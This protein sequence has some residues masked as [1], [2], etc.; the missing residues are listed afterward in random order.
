M[1]AIRIPRSLRAARVA[2]AA[3]LA[4]A[5]AAGTA[6]A[7]EDEAGE[8]I[9]VTAQNFER[10][11]FAD[12]EAPF[13]ID[14]LASDKFTEP[15]LD[16]PRSVTVI[17]ESV[18]ETLGATSFRELVRTTPGVTLGTGE[19]G[20]AFGDRI[21]IRGFDAR[22]D[23]YVDGVRDPG[24]TGREVF[25]VQQ[26]EIVKGPASTYGG[27]GTTG[28]TVSFVSKQPQEQAFQVYEATLGTDAT[29]RLTADV[30]VPLSSTVA[31][32]LNG[33]LYDADV[34]GRAEVWNQRWGVAAAI[35]WQ[36]SDAVELAADYYHLSTEGLPD[37]GVPFDAA[38]QQPF[39]VP[40][41]NFYGVTARDFASTDVD[42][43]TLRLGWNLAEG[44][45]LSSRLRYG[46]NWN[47]YIA[48]APER[49]VTTNPD[50]SKWT[51]S[52]NPK[53]R[54]AEAQ[55]YANATDLRFDFVTGRFSHALVSGF[56]FSRELVDNYPF[57]FASSETVGS[58]IVPA[59]PITQNL[60]NPDPGQAWPLARTTSGAFSSTKVV[61]KAAYFVDTIDLAP[62]WK[63]SG[64]L[65]YDDY[66]VSLYS[67]TASGASTSLANNSKFLN[68]NAG[69][70][71]KPAPAGSV[72][73]SASTSSNP[74]GEQTDGSG[75][76]Y[77]GLGPQTVNLDPE[78][79]RSFEAGVK[80]EV[81]DGGLLLTG[82]LFRTEKTN[83]RVNDP[84]GGTVQVLDGEQRVQG[85]EL[86]FSGNITSAWAVYG[87]YV[88]LDSEITKSSNPADVGKPF[89]NVA[90]NSA[91]LLS[92]YAF[93]P[94][95]T[96]GGQVAYV[97]QRYGG[98]TAAGTATIP[99]YWRF[100]AMGSYV[101]GPHAELQ[102][103]VLNLTNKVYYDAIYRSAT[104]FAYIAPGISALATLRLNF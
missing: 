100:D 84:L 14:R 15:L 25:A 81:A 16:T 96:A 82:A 6:H 33:V 5:V 30:N 71:W 83:A 40:R 86:G 52:A 28:G 39:D 7:E 3:A 51:V 77:G 63:L 59:I 54:N 73:L 27:R 1:T 49:P 103:N 66:A 34:A 35:L 11:P 10:N 9:V 91:S 95:F 13:K 32:R 70:V 58:P 20:N 102:V 19:G 44:V 42:I 55:I 67:R 88:F 24:V 17:P 37:W 87:G 62:G 43:A 50:P 74:S 104:P 78:E 101:I 56:E 21:F 18:I 22:N 38:T 29:K 98:S 47:S 8:Q 26:I 2:P 80:W 23:T 60:W 76:S 72:Y 90:R 69:L 85:F 31:V 46:S 97:G 75:I 92:T 64:G 68:W 61:S 57:A 12:P 99:A 89:P 45:R 94:R 41:H 53:N 36:V 48:S 79:N 65:R 93:T 4:L